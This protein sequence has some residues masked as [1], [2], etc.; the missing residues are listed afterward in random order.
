M[1]IYLMQILLIAENVI[2]Y[3]FINGIKIELYGFSYDEF[4]AIIQ[5]YLNWDWI[6]IEPYK[7]RFNLCIRAPL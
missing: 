7:K 6:T 3:I 2:T 4:I 1:A 5:L